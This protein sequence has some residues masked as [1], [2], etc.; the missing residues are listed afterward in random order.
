M[1]GAHDVR[2][3]AAPTVDFHSEELAQLAP[4]E[5]VDEPDL[6]WNN[7]GSDQGFVF[8][9]HHLWRLLASIGTSWEWS[10][11]SITNLETGAFGQSCGNVASGLAVEVGPTFSTVS[12][13]VPTG[14]SRTP[15]EDIGR[16][17]FAFKAS[18]DELHSVAIAVQIIHRWVTL[19]TLPEGLVLRPSF[20]R[21]KSRT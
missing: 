13:A 10:W 3:L 1:P 9:Q 21:T 17:G 5:A 18:P 11:V 12:L 6:R 15:Q 20:S 4:I 16:F 7:S 8:D 14:A 2:A 19:E